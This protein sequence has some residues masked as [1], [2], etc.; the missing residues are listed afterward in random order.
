MIEILEEYRDLYR[1][2]ADLIPAWK[3]MTRSE[4][5]YKYC[6]ALDN[7]D[8]LADSYL[9]VIICK[10]WHILTKYYNSQQIKVLSEFDAYECLID[11]IQ[12]TIESRPWKDSKSTVYNKPNAAEIVIN[13]VFKQTTVNFYVATTRHKRCI[14]YNSFSLDYVIDS[15]ENTTT[16]LNFVEDDTQQ[17]D[18]LYNSMYWVDTIKKF[19]TNKDYCSAFILD[20]FLN[21]DILSVSKCDDNSPFNIVLYKAYLSL[22]NYDSSYA[23]RFAKIYSFDTNCVKSA[24]KYISNITYK[25]FVQNLNRLYHV[26]KGNLSSEDI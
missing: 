6:E 5:C 1:A 21:T 15:D 23:E 13:N 11:A 16:M 4:A 26:L 18:N 19:F 22:K 2:S 8:S 17:M 7:N 14:N 12:F 9:S 25:H 10:F 20:L 3:N 24:I